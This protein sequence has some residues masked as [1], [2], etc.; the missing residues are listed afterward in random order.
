M[1]RVFNGK[2][3]RNW[4]VVG[5]DGQVLRYPNGKPMNDLDGYKSANEL[6]R[7][8]GGTAVRV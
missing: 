6:A 8:N 7:A 4:K 1:G 5:K 3:V 2:D